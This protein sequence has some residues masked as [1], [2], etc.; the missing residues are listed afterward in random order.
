[1]KRMAVCLAIVAG[2]ALSTRWPFAADRRNG[3]CSRLVSK[4]PETK[5]DPPSL[6]LFASQLRQGVP[7]SKSGPSWVGRVLQSPRQ[8]PDQFIRVFTQTQRIV[9]PAIRR[10]RSGCSGYRRSAAAATSFQ[11]ILTRARRRQVT[12]GLRRS[13][14]SSSGIRDSWVSSVDRLD[15]TL[16]R[17]AA[18]GLFA[19]RLPGQLLG[20]QNL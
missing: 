19:A 8:R 12:G 15:S 16:R 9:G 4:V 2:I 13:I 20:S 17:L 1:M 7:R 6:H 10:C 18:P 3:S 11:T 5:R 14:R